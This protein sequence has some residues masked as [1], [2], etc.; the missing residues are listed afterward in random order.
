MKY[1]HKNWNLLTPVIYTVICIIN[2]LNEYNCI[3]NSINKVINDGK[4]KWYL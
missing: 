1:V 2:T 3:I 4:T